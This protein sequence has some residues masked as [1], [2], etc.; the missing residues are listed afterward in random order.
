MIESH[1]AAKVVEIVLN[2]GPLI[3]RWIQCNHGFDGMPML[4]HELSGNLVS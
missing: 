3:R 1:P 4:T 2:Y